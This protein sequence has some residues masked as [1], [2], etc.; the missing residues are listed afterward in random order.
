MSVRGIRENRRNSHFRA[1]FSIIT[2]NT[3]KTRGGESLSTFISIGMG[4]YNIGVRL[5][6]VFLK[7]TKFLSAA[8]VMLYLDF[9]F[10]LNFARL[11]TLM[12]R[13][14]E[15]LT[16]TGGKNNSLITP[17]LKLIRLLHVIRVFESDRIKYTA[18]KMTGIYYLII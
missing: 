7:R 11:R 17:T 13:F 5:R 16:R 8:A 4:N 14:Y 12:Y 1:E 10:A 3:N 2:I 9:P 15:N 18:R 6:S